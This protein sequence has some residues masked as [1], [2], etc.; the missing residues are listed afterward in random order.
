MQPSWCRDDITHSLPGSSEN[1]SKRR[2]P[3]SDDAHRFTQRVAARL[4]ITA[5]HVL[6]AFE[7]PAERML[8]EVRPQR[9]LFLGNRYTGQSELMDLC[10]AEGVDVL[11]WFEAHRSNV[12]MLKRY[13]RANS[14]QHHGSL[15]KAS[16]QFV[17]DMEW[18]SAHREQLRREIADNYASGDWYCRGGTQFNRQI[19]SR[20]ETR[21]R[22][23]IDPEKR[24]AIIFAASPLVCRRSGDACAAM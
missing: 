24:T 3:L 6:P 20:E 4:G 18:T 8:K 16:W 15:S 23:G 10:I 12:L 5:D 1:A 19:V 14:D 21:K 17:Q 9:A 11:T 2:I 13:T 7:D 22:I